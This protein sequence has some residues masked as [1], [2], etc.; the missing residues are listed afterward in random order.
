MISG[1][2]KINE[3]AQIRL[4]LERNFGGVSL[5]MPQKI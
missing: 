4:I 3:F 2:V 1:G 5:T